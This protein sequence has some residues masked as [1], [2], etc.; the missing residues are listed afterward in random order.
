MGQYGLNSFVNNQ[1]TRGQG[2]IAQPQL[3]PVR[4]KSIILNEDHPKFT[5]LGEWNSLGAIEFEY[6]SNP[7][8]KSK[9]LSV[10]YPLQP[11]IKN[12]PLINEIVFLITLPSTGVGLTWNA[13]RSYYV[14]VVSLWNH[15]HHNA[16]PENPNIAPPSQVKDYTQTTAG[17]VKRIEDIGTEIYL[18]QTF[19]E[20]P[21]IHPLLPFEGDIIQEGRWGNSIRFGSTVRRGGGR[22]NW[23]SFGIDGDPL[24]ILRN[25]QP[26]SSSDEGWVPITEDI[27]KDL[28]S[29]YST[30]TQKI[31]LEASSTS[32]VSYKSDSPT[33][34]KEYNNNPQIILNSGRLIFNTTQ[35]HILLSSKKSI[36]LNAILSV[37]IDTPDTIIQSNNIY[38][39]S[40]DA[41]ESVLKGDT[42]TDLLRKLIKNL[43][44]F[45]IACSKQVGVPSNAPLAPL[46]KVASELVTTLSGLETNLNSI[47]SNR[48]KTV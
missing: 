1:F 34:P 37:N 12:Y 13:S 25:G 27:N 44:K 18:G 42:T 23:S 40:K 41:T 22:N 4:V 7:S 10:A 48:V 15:P 30:S 31:P 9:I 21:N 3:V 29:I 26:P 24:I 46:N 47:K 36:N 5:E 33:N 11:N 20:R 2:T 16:Y 19:L 38:L 6:I 43:E 39:G 45:M 17:S 32:Y 14:N 28:S 8:N 35:D